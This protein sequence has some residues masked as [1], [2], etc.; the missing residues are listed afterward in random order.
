MFLW[1]IW[2][3][4]TY[5]LQLGIGNLWS[6]GTL[7]RWCNLWSRGSLLCVGNMAFFGLFPLCTSLSPEMSLPR[8]GIIVF[9]SVLLTWITGKLRSLE[10]F[11]KGMKSPYNATDPLF[12]SVTS[13]VHEN[14]HQC[15]SQN[16]II[17]NTWCNKSRKLMYWKQN[18]IC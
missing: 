10:G 7:F 13:K 8:V 2:A 14:E 15:T 4:T 9:F 16:A 5:I 3:L 1:F 17:M 18:V 6:I 12:F 11:C